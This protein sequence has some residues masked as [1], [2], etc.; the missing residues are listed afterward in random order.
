[1]SRRFELQSLLAEIRLAKIGLRCDSGVLEIVSSR[2][3]IA[4]ELV[5]R[6]K[7]NERS[8]VEFL[9][10]ARAKAAREPATHFGPA[11]LTPA[12]V[13]ILFM[14]RLFPGCGLFNLLTHLDIVGPVNNA[15]FARAFRLVLARHPILTSAIVD[16]GGAPAWSETP[17]L[18]PAFAFVD[19]SALGPSE[20]E[21]AC[22]AIV[23]SERIRPLDHDC[24][25]RMLLCK[26]SDAHSRLIVNRHHILSDGW[27]FAI[28]SRELEIAY[29]AFCRG[30]PPALAPLDIRY[31]DY[32]RDISN[33]GTDVAGLNYWLS[34][35]HDAPRRVKL[36]RRGAGDRDE[37]EPISSFQFTL[38]MDV[39]SAASGMQH[40]QITPFTFLLGAF[41]LLLYRRTGELDI[42]VGTDATCRDNANTEGLIGLFVNRLVLRLR[43]RPDDTVRSFLTSAQQVVTRA[44]LRR[45]VPFSEIAHHLRSQSFSRISPLFNVL[46][47]MHNNPHHTLSLDGV[48]SKAIPVGGSR[49]S[50]LD[51]SLYLTTHSAGL[52]GE[53][54][55]RQ[56]LFDSGE[57]ERFCVEYEGLIL[58]LANGI[59]RPLGAFIGLDDAAGLGQ[60]LATWD[61]LQE[62]I[63]S[64]EGE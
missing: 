13:S 45:H 25:L 38:G 57:A 43:S 58:D 7:E 11:L 56:L 10:Q 28:L 8:I 22:N 51:L 48:R 24:W 29:K 30:S 42:S 14:E 26:L 31:H 37:L 19:L 60:N 32:C 4:R 36:D 16:E 21:R 47:G 44:L 34:E 5:A 33:R 39:L 1:M 2:G 6:I 9:M 27:S 61:T 52:T 54:Q 55:Y 46:F 18:Q 40:L 23:D 62:A 12:Q 20:R 3:P 41:V 59:D 17:T 64:S 63:L 49:Y 35:L 50:E 53:F 15:A